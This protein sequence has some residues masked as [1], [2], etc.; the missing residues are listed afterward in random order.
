M[1]VFVAS[2]VL[3]RAPRRCSAWAIPFGQRDELCPV[4]ALRAWLSAAG[5][6]DGR[7]FRSVT[8]HGR[9]GKSL[10]PASVSDVVKRYANAAGMDPAEFGGHSLR[11]GFVTSAAERGARTDRIMDHTGHKS[12]GMVRVYTRRSDAFADHAGAGLL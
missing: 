4:R 9:I 5:L 8:R 2:F 7:V 12:V 1:A 6:E 3:P 11:A 10:H